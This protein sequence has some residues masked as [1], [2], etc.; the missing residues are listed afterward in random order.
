MVKLKNFM[1]VCLIGN[2]LTSLI[3]AYILSNKNFNIEIYG[4]KSTKH[5][6]S[7][8]TLG[9][10]AS[11]LKYLEKYLNNLSRKTY[12]IDE[13]KVLIQNGK[14]NEEILFNQNSINLFNMIKYDQFIKIIKKKVSQKK[15]ILLK[16]IKKDSNLIKLI[17]KEKF[18]LIINCETNNILTKKFLSTGISK[19]Y[20]NKAFTAII[21]HNR[22]KN[23]RATQ[24]FTKYGPL[25][26]LPLSNKSTSV[27]FSFEE[28]IKSNATHQEIKSIINKFNPYYKKI[29]YSKIENF[30]LSL[31]LPKFYFFK[32][33]L[34]FGDNLHSIHP[35]AGQGFNMTIRDIRKLDEIIDSKTNLGLNINKSIYKEF[36]HE[37]KS[38]NSAFSLGVDLIYEFF[39]FNRNF[40]PKN[41]S[42]KLFSYVN[43]NEKLKKFGIKL[44]NHGAL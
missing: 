4:L 41:I 7:T 36:Q 29:S 12:S 1:K 8:R 14:I 30:K 44:A 26:Y 24:I 16:I 38:Q 35:L 27:V 37:A 19:N 15:N 17:S 18:E 13:I 11:N 20:H 22:I 28:K 23:N 40:I 3:L 25:A 5:V 2:N 9:I 42:E 43:K 21:S 34:F 33:V 32:N 39:R 6:F 10:T 31:K